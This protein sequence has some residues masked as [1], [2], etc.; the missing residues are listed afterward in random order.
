MGNGKRESDFEGNFIGKS[1]QNPLLDMSEY[2]IEYDDGTLDCM[3][4]NSIAENIY[5]QVDDEGR[6][7]VLLKEIVDHRATSDAITVQDG[8]ITM[9]NGR[10][11]PKC[12]TEGWELLV[13]WKDGSTSWIPLKDIKDMN[14]VEVAEYV[15]ATRSNMNP[16][17]LGR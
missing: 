3:F 16:H 14:P 8:F 6:H 15:I 11:V 4:A 1:H 10:K 7:F 9:P 5:S 2:I 12:T 17:L 13:E